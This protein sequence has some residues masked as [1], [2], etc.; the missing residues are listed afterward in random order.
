MQPYASRKEFWRK[1]IQNMNEKSSLYRNSSLSDRQWVRA[2][3]YGV[4]LTFVATDRYGRAELYIDRRNRKENEFIYDALMEHREQ[5]EKDFG[6][7]LVWE[8]R[9][10]ATACRI[11]TERPGNVFDE[12]EWDTMREFMV[13]S[14]LKLEKVMKPRLAKIHP[15]LH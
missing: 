8:Q 6:G 4:S 13:S 12:R 10:H 7:P 14:M 11:K 3:L 5:I 15:K 9:E 1:L 2:G